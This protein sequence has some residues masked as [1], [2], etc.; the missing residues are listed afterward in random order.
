[1]R[2]IRVVEAAFLAVAPDRGDALDKPHKE[3][4]RRGHRTADCKLSCDNAEYVKAV[5]FA[6]T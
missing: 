3:T 4:L 5:A 1:M 6:R 2:G